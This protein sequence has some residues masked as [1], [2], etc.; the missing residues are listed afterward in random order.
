MAIRY[1]AVDVRIPAFSRRRFSAVMTEEIL[2]RKKE[3]GD[4]HFIF[5]S[6]DYL[7]EM[8]IKHLNHAYYTD[9]ITFDY[10]EGDRISGD[11]FISL[12]RLKENAKTFDTSLEHELVRVM[13][14]G[15]FHLFGYRDK[16]AEEKMQMTELEENLL[17]KWLQS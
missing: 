13:S 16:T 12:D 10:V 9:V 11:I 8:N 5:C 4:I 6:D 14:H 15:V 17:K 2:Q 1:Y 3:R 7:L